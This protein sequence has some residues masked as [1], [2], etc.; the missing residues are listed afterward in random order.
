M[1]AD[2]PIPAEL[3]DVLR[4]WQAFRRRGWTLLEATTLQPELARSAGLATTAGYVDLAQAV[5]NF[6]LYLGSLVD[7]AVNEPTPVQRKRLI[8]L[9]EVVVHA[10]RGA[11]GA[12][13]ATQSDVH[14]V[15]LAAAAPMWE[16]IESALAERDLSL[17]RTDQPS[18]FLT[19]L[20]SKSLLAV[21]VDCD[22]LMD[23]GSV[24]DR[25]ESRRSKDRLGPTVV[26]LN[27]ARQLDQRLLALTSGADA[28]LEGEDSSYLIA[29]IG[30]LVEA[31]TRQ[32]HLKVLIVE[33]D[34]SQALYCAAILKKQ[35]IEVLAVADSCQALP[36]LAEF[37]PDLVLMDLHMPTLD[38]MQ[39]TAL[40]RED[41]TLALLPIVFLTGEQDEAR[42]F[43]A[44][45]V[46]GDDYMMKPV[47]PRHLVTAVV[48]R[49]RRARALRRQ[50]EQH[51]RSALDRCLHIG[52]FIGHLRAQERQ[53]GAQTLLLIAADQARLTAANAH[54]LREREQETKIANLLAES[55][56]PNERLAAWGGGGFLALLGESHGEELERRAEALRERLAGAL[57]T[58]TA[59]VAVV[60]WQ[61]DATSVEAVIDLAERTLVLARHAGGDKAQRALTELRTELDSDNSFVLQKALARNASGEQ[62][63]F[64]YQPIVPLHG[65]VR[66]Q[67]Q[68]HLRVVGDNGHPFTR[69]QWL[70]VAR[71]SGCLTK[72]DR[73]LLSQTLDQVMPLRE[74]YPTV[75]LVVALAAESLIAADFR[76]SL[77]FGLSQRGLLEPGL[78]LTVDES[79]ALLHLRELQQAR[80]E[81]A[82]ARVGVGLG[83]TSIHP[84]AHQLID[85]LKP[86]WVA[87]DAPKM[88]IDP[89]ASAVINHAH[90]RG[91]EVVAH[92]IPDA[93]AMARLFALGVDYGIGSFIGPPGNTAEFDFGA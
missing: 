48:T 75:R 72:L 74:R 20:G 46:G 19:W 51:A 3:I 80:L 26:F 92:F 24:A 87:L 32:E 5:R 49:A 30:E 22:F 15:A 69:R 12:Q 37:K 78:I 28:C 10:V 6:A 33:D 93:P 55:L 76:K 47:R 52:D 39:L 36:Q 27:R 25:I 77:L 66:P 29:R 62:L 59:S 8:E 58:G 89:E 38:G 83:R 40:I 56:A 4:R 42:R 35:G 65:A 70:E 9:E 13:A 23:L 64:E 85:S 84:R 71:Q 86:E 41:P 68:L 16:T 1:T 63:Q 21:L 14:I 53:S 67:F 43:D 18:Q 17:R 2:A 79:E 90:E 91:A 31:Q 11:R 45:Q 81:L 73:Y 57:E 44:L 60:P 50:F 7:G 61:A 88:L 82:A 34:R 54:P